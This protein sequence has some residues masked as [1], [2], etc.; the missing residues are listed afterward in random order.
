MRESIKHT[1]IYR[2]ARSLYIKVVSE[3]KKIN[4][5]EHRVSLGKKNPDKTFYVIRNM[6]GETGLMSYINTTIEHF[7][8]ADKNGYIP[9]VD[10][11]NYKSTYLDQ[12]LIGKENAWDY[13]FIQETDLA[14]VYKS[15]NV[16]MSNGDWTKTSSPIFMCDA[17]MSADTG[18]YN[19]IVD[20]HLR[21]NPQTAEH[22]EEEYKRL[23]LED[24]KTIGVVIRGTDLVNMSGHAKQPTLDEYFGIILG[25]IKEWDYGDKVALYIAS[26]EQQII[27]RCEAYF[28]DLGIKVLYSEA[29]RFDEI[30][31][32]KPLGEVTFKRSNDGYL[33]GIEYLTTICMLARCNAL[34][35]TKV[36]ATAG[37][38]LL[39]G[40]SYE[41]VE[42]IDMGVY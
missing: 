2:L 31:N 19:E 41:N 27:N 42:I 7:I 8:Y 18:E 17:L 28:K 5:E 24:Y 20:K 33:R 13:F 39:N 12:K 30:W 16:I 37:A 21:F 35:G 11:K 23:G 14:E 34:I 22:L 40:N 15:S 36:G 9:V 1:K 26:E 6:Y 38:L 3:R 32:G 4:Y 29:R 25:K 10:M